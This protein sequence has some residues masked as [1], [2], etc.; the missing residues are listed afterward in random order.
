MKKVY[1]ENII[2]KT[3]RASPIR[4]TKIRTH[5]V[6]YTYETTKIKDKCCICK[7]SIEGTIASYLIKGNYCSTCNTL[8]AEQNFIRLNKNTNEEK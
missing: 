4:N 7:G 1:T 8:T 5:T 3:I 2:E 6:I